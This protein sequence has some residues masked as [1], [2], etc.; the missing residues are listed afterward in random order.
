MYVMVGA[1]FA[2]GS[3]HAESISNSVDTALSGKVSVTCSDAK[4]WTFGISS[5]TEGGCD[6]VTVKATSPSEALPPVFDVT[7][8]VPGADIRQVWTSHYSAETP[9][10]WPWGWGHTRYTSQLAANTPIAVAFNGND[11]SCLAVACSEAFE[12]VA[13]GVYVHESRCVVGACF[14]FFTQAVLP[15]RSYEVTLRIDRRRMFWGDAVRE[16]SEWIGKVS[17]FVNASVP[18]A[19]FDPLYSTWYA[20]LQNV[21]AAELEKEAAVAASLGMKVMILDDGWQKLKSRTFY[22]ATGDWMPVQSRFPDMRA[23]VDAV[24]RAGLKYMLWVSVPFVGS[25]S[26]AWERFKDKFLKMSGSDVGVLDPR[27]PEVREYLIQTYERIV[28]DWDFDGVKLDFID[29]FTLPGKDPAIKE[30]YAGRDIRSLP[31]AVD[32]LMKDVL[33]RLKAIKPD[34]LVEFRQAYMGPAILQYGNMIRAADVPADPTTNRK[35]IADL[36]LTSGK[37]SVHSDMIV[38]DPSE[39]PEGA[40]RPILSAIFGTIQ[41]SMVLARIPAPHRDVIRHWLAFSLRHREALLKGRFRPHHPELG[42]PFIEAESDSE[43]VCA[44]YAKDWTVKVPAGKPSFVINSSYGGSLVMDLE[45]AP[46]SV[47]AFDTFGRSVGKCT[48]QAGLHRVDVPP[49]GYLHVDF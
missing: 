38:W 31:K 26:K 5:R 2:C 1:A 19:A 6:L 11:E 23:H 9:R 21:H 36:R 46:K 42:Y 25:E 43:R 39:T 12:H 49:S 40:A 34:V 8:D 4:G 45:A 14:K 16:S 22:S 20:Y 15:I 7:F 24:H 37:A 32:R 30:G 47:E 48:L 3:L 41:Y 29:K 33:A 35:R 10:L 44:V 13:Y 28:R 27:F 17:G 18:E